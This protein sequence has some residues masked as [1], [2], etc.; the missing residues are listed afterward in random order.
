MNKT[1]FFT[2]IL[3][4]LAILVSMNAKADLLYQYTSGSGTG[5]MVSQF[6]A[7]TSVYLN[8]GHEDL[9]GNTHL[10]YSTYTPES[11]YYYWNGM[12]PASAVE[13]TGISSMR[14]NIDTCTVQAN[15]AC[16]L[17]DVSFTKDPASTPLIN[18]GVSQM[19]YGGVLYQTAGSYT[20]YNADAIGSIRGI[21]FTS[22][23]RAW[24]SRYSN[25]TVTVTSGN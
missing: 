18:T 22:T 21:A 11:G 20:T 5:A 7:G 19:M 12:V 9:S 23:N 4:A 17:V 14:I 8:I 10:I 15:A 24:L 2:S 25:V 13:T 16:G 6:T 1:S 3:A